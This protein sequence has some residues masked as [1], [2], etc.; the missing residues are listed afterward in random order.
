MRTGIIKMNERSTA[1]RTLYTDAVVG[2]ALDVL[3]RQACP[4]L[5]A[6]PRVTELPVRM[7]D[8]IGR[9]I[10]WEIFGDWLV[11]DVSVPELLERE[12]RART[13]V[14]RPIFYV[15]QTPTD[16][17][18]DVTEIARCEC[19]YPVPRVQAGWGIK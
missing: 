7:V 17:G 11:A 6:R 15:K 13:Y 3:L 18:I 8:G 16:R 10:G 5:N 19:L 1:N 14:L 2:A 12:L 4:I 9:V